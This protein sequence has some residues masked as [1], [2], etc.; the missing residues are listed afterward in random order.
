MAQIKLAPAEN[1]GLYFTAV[2]S[3]DMNIGTKSKDNPLSSCREWK[4]H[5]I[6]VSEAAFNRQCQ[7]TD[8]DLCSGLK[9]SK[10]L[11]YLRGCMERGGW[12]E[13]WYTTYFRSSCRADKR[14]NGSDLYCAPLR[15]AHKTTTTI[16]SRY[17]HTGCGK[18]QYMCCRA[19]LGQTEAWL[20]LSTATLHLQTTTVRSLTL[21]GGIMGEGRT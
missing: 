14:L 12:W 20:P 8:S 18:L 1:T 6:G 3:G 9:H 15:A 13:G 16:Y 19:A 21:T 11:R 10:G 2:Y 5:E 4:P 17:I 7:R